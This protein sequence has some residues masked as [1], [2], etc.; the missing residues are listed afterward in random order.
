[1]LQA[2]SEGGA[3]RV[4]T[5]LGSS[6]VIANSVFESNTAVDFGGALDLSDC[7]VLITQCSFKDNTVSSALIGQ[8]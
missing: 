8:L 4:D 3:I 2:G 1:L 7:D 6:V 5:N